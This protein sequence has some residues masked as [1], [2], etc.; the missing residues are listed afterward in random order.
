MTEQ[1]A[2]RDITGEFL[3]LHEFVLAA[4][5]K[6]SGEL[7][8]FLVGGAETE[9]TLRRNRQALDAIAL[10]PRVLRDVSRV[11][12]AGGLFD[13]PMRL[14]VVLA[15]IGS[16]ES[17]DPGGTAMVAKAAAEFGVPMFASSVS[18]PSIEA[19][20]AAAPGR[21]IFQLYV[22]G[23]DAWVDERVRRAIA[24]GYEAL[25][26]TVDTASYSRRERD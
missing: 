20:A 21:K 18:A 2:P 15:P 13:R 16:I 9:T 6:L 25:C 4:R 1:P 12:S 3:T 17:Y 23:D 22:R 14:P 10:R 5:H 11:D 26:L 8:D 24:A 7:W 19:T